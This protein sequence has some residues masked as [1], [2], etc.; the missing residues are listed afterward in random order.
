MHLLSDAE[1]TAASPPLVVMNSG[2][3]NT[4]SV[5]MSETL[6]NRLSA[7]EAASLISREM[8]RSGSFVSKLNPLLNRFFETLEIF[9]QYQFATNPHLYRAL[10]FSDS[11]KPLVVGLEA[12]LIANSP[13]SY[14]RHLLS[15][16]I[17]RAASFS[18][19]ARAGGETLKN[20]LQKVHE[21]NVGKGL[22]ILNS[23]PSDHTRILDRIRAMAESKQ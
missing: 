13:L 3:N 11:A 16:K 21:V 9:L 18:A 2:K 20:A 7:A 15:K 14:V 8:W 12:F 22:P 17:A 19:D 1:A 5:E 4:V 23:D 6:F 10:G